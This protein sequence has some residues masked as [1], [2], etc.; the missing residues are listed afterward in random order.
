MLQNQAEDDKVMTW[1][2]RQK[3]MTKVIKGIKKKR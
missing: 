3:M 2:I 1:E